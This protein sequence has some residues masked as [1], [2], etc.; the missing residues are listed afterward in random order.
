MQIH[1]IP[2]LGDNYCHLVV[3][4][5]TGDAAVVD[6]AEPQPVIEAIERAGVVL[7]HILCTHHHFDHAGGNLGLLERYPKAQ[8]VGGAHDAA[9][10]PGISIQV[11]H[12]DAVEMGALSG[13]VL[14][15]PCHTSGHVAYL[16]EDA[17]FCGDTLFVGGCGRFFEGDAEQMHHALNH[18][19]AALPPSTRVFCGHEY[20]VANLEFAVGVEP[21]NAAARTKLD[22][23]RAQQA[24]GR[25][26]VPSTLK[27]ELEHNPFM[28]VT[29][30][31]IQAVV[32]ASDPV[33][34][35]AALRARK[36]AS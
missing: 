15:V 19:F 20:T 36:N 3:D 29:A 17:L 27:E 4:D 32:G 25:S 35:M 1:Q 2:I 12:D 7:T 21:A 24:K 18:V 5:A 16:F 30:A 6:P 9:R 34:V 26:T 28:R 13:R 23:A 33:S 11:D 10:I 31:T 14:S 22:W 8:I